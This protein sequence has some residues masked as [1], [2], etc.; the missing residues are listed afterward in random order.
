MKNRFST[1]RVLGLVLCM[2]SGSVLSQPAAAQVPPVPPTTPAPTADVPTVETPAELRFDIGRFDVQGNTLLPSELVVGTVAPFAG[3]GRDF[4]DVQRA[5]EALENVYRARGLSAVQVYLPEQE[6]DKGVVVLKVI[7]ARITRIEIK[8]NKFFDEANIRA[9]LTSIRVGATPNSN[10]VSRNLRIV[11]ESPAKQTNVTLRAGENEGEVEATVDVADE[12]PKKWFLT[13]DNTGSGSTGYHRIGAGFQNS[14]LFG[15]DHAITLQYVTSLEVPKQVSVYSIGYHLPLYTQGASMDFVL[16]Y[17][18]VN[19]GSTLTPAGPLTFTGRG[20]VLGVR[21]NQQLH[22][23]MPGYEH[24]LVWAVDH[25][26]YRNNCALGVFGAAGCGAAAATYS[27]SPVS[28]NYQGA[29]SGRGSQLS[30]NASANTNLKSGSHGDTE[31]LG[32]S[33]AGA[34]T[35]YWV[36]RFGVNYLQVLDEDWQL[37][38]R[39]DLQHTN[40]VLVAPEHFGIGGQSSV[41]GFME[42]ERA[43]DR[44]HS[45]SLEVYTPDLGKRLGLGEANLRLLG[46]YDFG[47]TFRVQPLAGETSTNGIASAGL[48]LRYSFQ[49]STSIRFDV[50]QIIDE[51]GTRVKG[52][53]RFHLGGVWSF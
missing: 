38:G 34:K 5:L 3:A 9:S 11:N 48:G 51:G 46:F 33:R 28:L 14:N 21:Y 23:P 17:S 26:M 16:G 4:G 49:K 37:R 15:R 36:Y 7:E 40:E 24:K 50:A 47:R 39:F 30:F 44:G 52:H 27:L 8:G 29:L 43:D 25:R 19:S 18:D 32:R 10:E 13:F 31:A 42:R 6:L 1:C 53:L 2:L 41:R 22:R 45:G 12:N 20:G 35:N